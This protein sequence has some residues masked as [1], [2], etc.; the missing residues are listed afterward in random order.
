M[1]LTP[2]G[3]FSPREALDQI[4]GLL[5]TGGEDIDPVRYGGAAGLLG[6]GEVNPERDALEFALLQAALER[7]LPVLAVCRGMQ[8][9]NVALGGRL[10]ADVPGHRVV[11]ED[12]RWASAYHRIWVSPGSKLAS[13]LG[14]GGTV[15]VN[16]RHHQG[17]REAQKASSLL[18]CAYSLDD[19]LVEG[20][21]SPHHAWVLGVQFHPERAEE[22]P[23]QFQRL[24][25]ALVEKASHR[26]GAGSRPL[27]DFEQ[28]PFRGPR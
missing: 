13:A 22:L 4:D 23:K 7:D 12:G 26:R 5:L 17:L 27:R 14:S 19:S 28:D 6:S 15:R 16:S 24:F 25:G 9:L 2:A 21:E 10:L 18:A 1:L 20:L 3:T 11:Q 8:V